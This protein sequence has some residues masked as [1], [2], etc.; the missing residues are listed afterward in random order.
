MTVVLHR[1]SRDDMDRAAIIHR[2]SFDERLPWLAGLHT[3]AA[4]RAYYRTC[5]FDSCAIWGATRERSLVGFI[6]FRPDWIDQL[7]VLPGQQRS[8]A[9]QALLRVAQVA[10]DGLQLWTFQRNTPARRFYERHGFVAIRTTNGARNEEREP[11][12]LYR[13]VRAD[14]DRTAGSA[15]PTYA[16]PVAADGGR[17]SDRRLVRLPERQTEPAAPAVR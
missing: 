1:L 7:Y 15:T 11:D 16:R 9:G 10:S 12:V 14:R 2:A 4:D 8:G 6:A 5:V 17:L 13:W 3:P